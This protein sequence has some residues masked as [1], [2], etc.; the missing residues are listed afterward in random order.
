MPDFHEI[1]K[2]LYYDREDTSKPKI[3]EFGPN[4][5]EKFVYIVPQVK[6]VLTHAQSPRIFFCINE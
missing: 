4:D 6:E 2:S 3:L 1:K 5:G